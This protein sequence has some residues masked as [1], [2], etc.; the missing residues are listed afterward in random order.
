MSAPMSHAA[1][2]LAASR[3]GKP[4]SSMFLRMLIRAAVLRRGRALSALLAMVVAAAVATA[5]MNLYVDVQAKLQHEFRNYGANIVIVGRNGASLPADSQQRVESILAGRGL[6]APFAMIVARTKDGQPVVAVG[7]DFD[8][9]R[10]LDHW[11]SVSHWPS[12][13]KQALVGV[14]AL[15]VVAPKNQAF[16]LSFQGHLISLTPAGTVRTGAAEDSRVYLS[17]PDFVAWTGIQPSTIEVAANGSP[18]EIA[19]VMKRLSQVLPSADVR[20]VRQ[21]VE[22]EARVLGKTRATLL[23][24]SVL[25]ILTAALCVLSTLMGWVFDRRRDFAIMKALGASGRLLNSF[26]AAEAAALGATGAVFGFFVGLGIAAWIGR[27][28]FHAAVVPR[29]GV[30]P[31]VLAGSM[32]VT[33]ISAILPISLLRRV[34]PAVILRGE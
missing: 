4:H 1:Q 27:A 14:R 19:A 21:I 9:V 28:N 8:R 7:T 11:W 20:P 13:P 18:A 25:I 26:F 33:L 31:I 10:Q 32:A 29:F 30:L 34:Q 16:D 22:G 3:T 15:E 5:V 23:A 6:V 17:L 24:A 2:D 12:A